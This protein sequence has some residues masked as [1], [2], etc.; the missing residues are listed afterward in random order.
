MWYVVDLEHSSETCVAIKCIEIFWI[1]LSHESEFC[2]RWLVLIT[3]IRRITAIDRKSSEIHKVRSFFISNF[4]SKQHYDKITRREKQKKMK[5][6][7]TRSTLSGFLDIISHYLNITHT[8]SQLKNSMRET[9]RK[10]K[11]AKSSLSWFLEECLSLV[12][13]IL[14]IYVL[15]VK[16]SRTF[17]RINFRFMTRP[18]VMRDDSMM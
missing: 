18:R 16:K 14:F 7:K 2:R 5:Y 11:K 1:V 6:C 17:T 13:M 15:R 12:P 3:M 8:A 4:I 10:V 9:R